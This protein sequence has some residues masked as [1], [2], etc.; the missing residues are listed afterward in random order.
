MDE[1]KNKKN[2]ISGVLGEVFHKKQHYKEQREFFDLGEKVNMLQSKSKFVIST[3]SSFI[4]QT[5]LQE[6][7]KCN[8]YKAKVMS[9]GTC[10]SKCL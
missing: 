4:V 1:V 6:F 7:L 10:T 3:A 8:W 2:I 5:V 9:Q